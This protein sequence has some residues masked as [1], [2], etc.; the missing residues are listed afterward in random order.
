MPPKVDGPLRIHSRCFH[1]SNAPENDDIENTLSCYFL[2]FLDALLCK[3][4]PDETGV[5]GEVILGVLCEAKRDE[6][7]PAIRA[8]GVREVVREED[9]SVHLPHSFRRGLRQ[10]AIRVYNS[11]EVDEE[12]I[13]PAFEQVLWELLDHT[14]EFELGLLDRN[15]GDYSG[16]DV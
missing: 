14:L 15:S 13:V 8:A 10:Q 2:Q 12:L 1:G 6:W 7:A 5:V 4:V 9:V 3:G 11:P 16:I